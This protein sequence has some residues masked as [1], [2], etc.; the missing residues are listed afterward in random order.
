MT[1]SKPQ[2][3]QQKI[4]LNAKKPHRIKA[5]LIAW[6]SASEKVDTDPFQLDKA[7][8]WA[9]NALAEVVKVVLPGKRLPTAGEWDLELVGELFGRLQAFVKLYGGEI[10]M[11]PEV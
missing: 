8:I 10:P 3:K 9:E 11:G 6:A 1:K 7:P 5:A 4:K 2:I